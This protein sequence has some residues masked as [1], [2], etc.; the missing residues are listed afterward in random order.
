[1]NANKN[2]SFVFIRVYSWKKSVNY[3]QS[4]MK[5]ALISS[6]FTTNESV[7]QIFSLR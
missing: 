1:M 6:I 7:K 2:K 5:D 4:D 3:F